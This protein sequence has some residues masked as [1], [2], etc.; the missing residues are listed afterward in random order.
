M[1]AIDKLNVTFAKDMKKVLNDEQFAA[2]VKKEKLK[3]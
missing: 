2:F 1:E 3:E